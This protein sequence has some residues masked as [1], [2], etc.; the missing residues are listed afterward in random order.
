VRL[1]NYGVGEV[2]DRLS[3]LALKRLFGAQTGKDITHFTT[4]HTAL[5]SEI[6]SRTL[7]GKWFEAYTELAA[8]NAA[9]WHAEDDLRA[10]RM[11]WD[12]SAHQ[13]IVNTAFRIQDLNDQRAA[14]I[15][16]INKDTGEVPLG[17][18]KVFA[19]VGKEER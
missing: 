2:S 7:N 18:E 13:E 1:K 11:V 9:L 5:L 10:M 3:I 17:S 14:L 16:R 15:E 8:V 6:R 19:V 4:E 12:G